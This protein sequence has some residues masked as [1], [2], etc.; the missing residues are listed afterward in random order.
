MVV[1]SFLNIVR[2]K[3]LRADNLERI[4][5]TLKDAKY[6]EAAL[7]TNSDATA[8]LI[9]YQKAFWDF[10]KSSYIRE[11]LLHGQ[12]IGR[13]HTLDCQQCIKYWEIFLYWLGVCVSLGQTHLIPSLQVYPRETLWRSI[14]KRQ[15]NTRVSGII[16]LQDLSKR[17]P[18]R[19]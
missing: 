2:S 9:E 19:H 13:Y 16:G 14:I 10:D 15:G 11:K 18:T 8:T 5:D 6:L 12:R 17:V 4:I 3:K 1:S 7:V